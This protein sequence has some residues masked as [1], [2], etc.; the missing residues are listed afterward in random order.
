MRLTFPGPITLFFCLMRIRMIVRKML[1][2]NN[3]PLP[4]RMPMGRERTSAGSYGRCAIAN[5]RRVLG[6]SGYCAHCIVHE[7]YTGNPN[8]VGSREYEAP[9]THIAAMSAGTPTAS[10]PPIVVHR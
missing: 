6:K 1:L 2:A 10:R 3:T 7:D 8:D 4:A 9:F 5:C